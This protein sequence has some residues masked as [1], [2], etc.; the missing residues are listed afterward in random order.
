MF[1]FRRAVVGLR[2]VGWY[3]FAFEARYARQTAFPAIGYGSADAVPP[4]KPGQTVAR[5]AALG[6]VENPDGVTVKILRRAQRIR[7]GVAVARVHCPE[8]CRV[9]VGAPGDTRATTIEGT[10][11]VG[12][13]QVEVKPGLHDVRVTID[14]GLAAVGRSRLAR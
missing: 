10:A 11:L 1:G 2:Y 5:S 9:V 4:L 7:G 8:R 3:V 12:P 13:R 14:G 6:P